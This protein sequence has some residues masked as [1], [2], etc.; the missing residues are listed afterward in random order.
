MDVKDL[1]GQLREGRKKGAG[2]KG[3]RGGRGEWSEEEGS[4][5]KEGKGVTVRMLVMHSQFPSTKNYTQD[6]PVK[7]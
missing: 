2:E 5:V 7:C 4:G 6:V 3:G 1:R